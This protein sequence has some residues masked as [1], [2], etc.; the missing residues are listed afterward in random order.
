MDMN[1]FLNVKC[2]DNAYQ[3]SQRLFRCYPLLFLP[4]IFYRKVLKQ[5]PIIINQN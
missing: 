4:Y 5:K 2:F 3:A 1:S